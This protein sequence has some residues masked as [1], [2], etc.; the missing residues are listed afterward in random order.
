LF[1]ALFVFYNIAVSNIK[2]L[3]KNIN[4]ITFL[5]C[6]AQHKQHV[7]FPSLKKFAKKNFLTVTQNTFSFIKRILSVAT[8]G[9][10]F[11]V[12]TSMVRIISVEVG[13]I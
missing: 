5:G 10:F 1:G 4:I 11:Y 6:R 7:L 8:Q 3:I 2:L 13:K 12:P 9:G